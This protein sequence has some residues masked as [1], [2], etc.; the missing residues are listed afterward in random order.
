MDPTGGP[1]CS[2]ASLP[3][4]Q[5]EPWKARACAHGAPQDNERRKA[6]EGGGILPTSEVAWGLWITPSRQHLRGVG[7]A[8]NHIRSWLPAGPSCP[9]PP[10]EPA[11]Q[12]W[13]LPAT[14]VPAAADQSGARRLEECPTRWPARR[15]SRRLSGYRAMQCTCA[16]HWPL[17]STFSARITQ[18]RIPP[19]SS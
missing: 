12:E 17:Q 4:S 11:F 3:G 8:A 1:A 6:L 18:S 9:T 15:G 7:Q 13:V 10:Q 16:P 14:Q 2:L 19:G 5:P